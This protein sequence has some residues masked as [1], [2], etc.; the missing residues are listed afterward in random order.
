MNW[1]KKNWM[2]LAIIVVLLSIL[3]GQCRSNQVTKKKLQVSQHNI[4]VLQDSV[5]K[6]TTKDGKPEFDKLAFLTDKV[7]NLEKLS[8][9]L[10]LEVKNTKGKTNTII[11]GG[12]QLVHDTTY[13]ESEANLENDIV[14]V[15]FKHD[16]TYSKGNSRSIA[17]TTTYDILTDVSTAKITKDSLYMTFVTGI[18][19]LDVGKPEIFVRSDYPGF[20]AVN[21]E[22]AVLD[23]SI[24]QPKNKQKLITLGLQIG[25]TPLTYSLRTQRVDFDP[26]RFGVGAGANINL[27]RLF[28]K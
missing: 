19:N 4:E 17:G 24:F 2:L 15:D 25:Y 12:V 28:G 22:G 21:I 23:K 11:K 16:T 14:T 3:A 5:R 27:S 18:K 13:L 1:I 26:T 6:A 9:D 10:Y 7:S 8:Q 20:S